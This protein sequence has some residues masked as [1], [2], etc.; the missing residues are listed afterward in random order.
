MG[1]GAARDRSAAQAAFR[2]RVGDYLSHLAQVRNLSPNTVRGYA[3]D[4]EAYCAWVERQGLD[5]LDVTHRQL[6]GFL[7]ELSRARYSTRTINR[8]L[9]AIRGLYRW[10]LREG[11]ATKDVAAAVASP[12]QGRALP[13]TMSDA[14]VR[15]LLESCDASEAVG[16]R[17]RAFLELL[18]ASGARI[19]EISRLDVRDVDFAQAQV[20]LF[21]K[22]SRERIVPLYDACLD[23]LRAYLGQPRASL[24]ARAGSPDARRA[25]FISTRGNRMSAD[26]L[27]TCFEAHARAA[28]LDAGLTPHAM[29]HTYAT[30]LLAGGA[31]LRS[32]QELLGHASLSTTQAYTHLSVDRL[33][34]AARQ[35]H[36]RGE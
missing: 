34:Q 15:S 28:G 25:L 5:P 7:A 3:V 6:R 20:R 27:R 16:V 32:V 8:H 22:G 35:A 1:E 17:D 24:A 36:P 10:M 29:R 14:D 23:W 21:G 30:E 19:S 9:S 4:L 33:K 13:K 11:L 18:Y 2:G 31:D 26:A 12:R